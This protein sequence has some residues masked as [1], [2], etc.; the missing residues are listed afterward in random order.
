[1]AKARQGVEPGAVR[2]P[3]QHLVEVPLF[4]LGRSSLSLPAHVGDQQ[5]LR[6]IGQTQASGV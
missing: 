2:S 6:R 3:P 4:M 1:L 5:R